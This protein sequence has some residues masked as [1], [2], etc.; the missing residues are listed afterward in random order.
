M[1]TARGSDPFV[2]AERTPHG[3]DPQTLSRYADQ[4]WDLSPLEG[5]G[6]LSHSLNIGRFGEPLRETFRQATWALV[7]LPIADILTERPGS[8]RVQRPS[9]GTILIIFHHWTLFSKWALSQGI[10]QLCDLTSDDLEAY[11]AAVATSHNRTTPPVKALYSVSVLWGFAPHLP[12]HDRLIRP[13]WEDSGLSDYL[14]PADATNENRTPPIHPAVMSPLLIWAMRFVDDFADDILAAWSERERLLNSIPTHKDRA[15]LDR[16]IKLLNEYRSAGKPLP[17]FY[18]GTRLKLAVSY[19]AA[20]ANAAPSQVAHAVERYGP[21]LPVA[22]TSPLCT[23]INGRLNGKPWLPHI[24]FHETAILM[25]RLSAACTIVLFYL[26]GMRTSEG[27]TLEPGCCPEP[28]DDG[29]SP[30]RCTIHGKHFKNARDHNGNHIAT[31]LPREAPWTVIP[32]VMR[33][34]R[35]LEQM[36]DGPYLFPANPSWTRGGNGHRRAHAGKAL[37]SEAANNRLQLF[38]DWINRYVRD[39]GLD[40]QYIPAD[41]DGA[42][43]LSRFRRTIAWH[44][45]RLPGGIVAL[46]T[47][48]GHLRTLVGEGYSGRAR[49][50][51]RRVLDIETARAMSDYLDELAERIDT[52]EAL[53]GPAAGRMIAA[54]RTART[55]F[56]G[57]FLTPKQ[58]DALAKDPRLQIYDNPAAFLTCNYDPVKALCHPERATTSAQDRPPALNRCN[59]D[60]ANIARTDIHIE[61]LEHEI[62]DLQREIANTLTPTPLRERLK[63]R[64]TALTRIRTRHRTQRITAADPELAHD[65]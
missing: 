49:T 24:N 21:D 15:A 14:P 31:G 58:A 13:P 64:V 20:H 26:S 50:G 61:A 17:G 22:A 11:A 2:I 57:M 42:I 1:W 47:Q 34:I 43:V 30:T 27:L 28:A 16:A 55:R 51:L 54:I 60:C 44:I 40:S 12:E 63:Q 38:I 35:V 39:N 52:G 56:G 9:V 65:R 3:T 32:P 4:R 19:L 25:V 6:A 36:V 62:T 59:P 33:A 37:S 23:P 46:S 8:N 29:Q 10:T 45:A 7:N 41:P 18:D 53:S 48:Y 5:P